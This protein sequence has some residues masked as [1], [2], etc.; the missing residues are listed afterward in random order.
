MLNPQLPCKR[1]SFAFYTFFSEYK[2]KSNLESSI[3][4]FLKHSIHGLQ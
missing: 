1:G 4:N 2:L 3:H